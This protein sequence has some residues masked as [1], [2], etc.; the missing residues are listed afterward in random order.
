MSVRRYVV[1]VF[2]VV[3]VALCGS[4]SAQST[5]TAPAAGDDMLVAD[6][7]LALKPVETGSPRETMQTFLKAMVD[8]KKGL[9]TDDPGLK[10]RLDDAVRC[11]DLQQFPLLSRED[12]GRESAIL[13]KEVMDRV[14][15]VDYSRIP[16]ESDVESWTLKDTE[17]TIAKQADGE[18]AGEYLFDYNTVNQAHTWYQKV[19]HLPYIG[20]TTGAGYREPWIERNVPDWAKSTTILFPNWQW[21][22]IFLSILLGLVV[23]TV[24]TWVVHGLK[25]VTERSKIEW[26][27]L[28]IE[29][30]ERPAGLIAAAIFWYFA[31]HALRFEG[32]ALT[33]MSMLV[34]VVLSVAV[35]WAVYRLVDVVTAWLKVV[36]GKTETTLDD[37][38]VP[39]VRRALR[40]FTVIFGVLVTIQNLGVNVLSVL[41]GL[42]LGG[43]AF[44]L[45]AKDTCA[46][47]FGSIMIILD[48]P[49]QVGDWV[50][51]GAVEGSV[52]EIGFR[53]TRVRTFYNSVI[54]VPNSVM[55][56][57]NIDNMGAREYRRIKTFFGLTYDTPPE[58]M[59]AFIEG[60][61]NIVKSNNYTR[62]DYYHVVFNSYGPD[63][64]EVM[65]Y[66][67]L[68][69][70]DWAT[71]LVERQ[72]I[73]LEIYRLA[74]E[75]KV[76]FAFPTRTLNIEQMPE[77][78]NVR[79]PHEVD[80]MALAASAA[81]FG[82]G[83]ALAKPGGMGLFTPPHLEAPHT[84]SRGNDD[85]GE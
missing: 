71:E 39:L 48:R 17:I 14:I 56:N 50:I 82:P 32:A 9:D 29:S 41:A 42:G 49:F 1:A 40:I 38:L 12:R 44:A 59:E 81:A 58:K 78:T 54:S 55:A 23:K 84:V 31:V 37:Q 80:D 66:C 46:N 83:G 70:P 61:K 6:A 3:F 74:A 72:N 21:I 2:A 76:E 65:L 13:L 35:I 52:E 34:Q 27:D 67:F 25:K 75:L 43:L 62:K 85:S 60:V 63:Y 7:R 4:L 53:S 45:A 10:A 73:Y 68:K 18:N 47:L 36:T 30:I 64:L 19:K 8:Y 57:A 79:P 28:V 5:D 51:V 22:S 69:V 77:K 26:D 20:S 33:V 11:L 15:M 16:D 24:V